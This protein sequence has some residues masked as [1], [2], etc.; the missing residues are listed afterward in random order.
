MQTVSD[1]FMAW[2]EGDMRPLAWQF[3]ASFDKS[4]D[5]D[6]TFFTLDTS[7]LDG[8]DI[9]GYTGANDITEWDKYNYEPYSDRVISMEWQQEFSFLSSTTAA[10]ADIKLNN[11][12]HLFT[13]QA[14]SPL[15]P[16]ILPRRPIRLLAGFGDEAIP[17]FVGLTEKIPQVDRKALTAA[18]HA[19]DFLSYMFTRKLDRT[20]MYIDLRVDE[21]LAELF[22]LFGVLPSQMLLETAATTVPFAFFEKNQTLGGAV[23]DLMKAEM[24]SLYM[25]EQGFIVFK[26][27]LRQAGTPVMTFDE[28]NIIDYSTSN[29]NQII[30]NVSVKSQVRVVQDKQAV[31]K[32]A[33]TI[34]IDPGDTISKFFNFDDPVTAVDTITFY[35]ANSAQDDS[36]TD[37]TSD[38]TIVDQTLFSTSILVEIENTGGTVAYLTALVVYGTPAK[39]TKTV[40]VILKDQDSIDEF[41]DQTYSIESKYIQNEDTARSIG[42][43]ILR[44]FKDFNNTITLEVKSNP[45]LQINDTINVVI[46]GINDNF[47]INKLRQV[48]QDGRLQ[49]TITAQKID[50]TIFFTLDVSLLDGTDVLA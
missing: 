14:G 35:T 33:E 50:A 39:I 15:D 48:L 18:L 42:L 12:D 24:G 44:R 8:V 41:E 5:P 34:Q 31:F 19:Q 1:Q 17:Q 45:A 4:F 26:N 36:G 2:A 29:E 25:D 27:R 30:N 3:R 16:Y 38:I 23:A 47:V 49:Q 7:L 37:L 20:V 43:N 22:A 9:L 13:K 40:D 6:I 21:I 28:T 11:Y 10:M 32:L 46:D